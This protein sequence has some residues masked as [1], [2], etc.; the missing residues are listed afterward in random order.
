MRVA[1]YRDG[2]HQV[3]GAMLSFVD[4]TGLT[5]AEQHQRVLIAELQHR[6]R[7]LLQVVQA[8]VAQTL[9]RASVPKVLTERLAALGRVQSLVSRSSG[10]DVDLGEVVRLELQAYAGNGGRVAAAGPPVPLGFQRVQILA[11]ALHELTTNAV[12]H[13]AL[14]DDGGRLDIRWTV[15][16]GGD[17]PLLVLDW[18]ESG[19]AMPAD[20]PRRGYGRE[21]IERA[22]TYTAKAKTRLSFGADGVACR[23]EMPLP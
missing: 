19:V 15:E 21:L 6:T 16:R 9:G 11:L 22:L 8:I 14:R 7:N 3:D 17:V 1:P 10:H 5:E 4:V 12:K 2:E 18:R 13:G 23:I 20:T